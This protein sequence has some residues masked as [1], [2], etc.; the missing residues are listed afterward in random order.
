MIAHVTNDQA[1]RWFQE[2]FAQRVQG[3]PYSA[4]AL[5][6][7]EDD[8]LLPLVLL[9]P[10]LARSPD[11]EMMGAG[12]LVAL[13]NIR[14]LEDKYG[15]SALKQM[16]TAFRSGATTEEA[17]RTVCKKSMPELEREL[18]QWGRTEVRVFDN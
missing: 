10:V 18:R 7:Y 15:P 3:S 14:F 9:D 11:P 2:G 17:V 13:A 6:M 12:Y 16:M 8:K 5:N 1:P 4:N